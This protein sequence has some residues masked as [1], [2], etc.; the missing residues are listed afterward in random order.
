M[1][2]PSEEKGFVLITALLIMIILTLVGIGAILN[3]SV[4]INISRNERLHKEA[5]YSADAGGALVP[6]IIN[7]YMSTQP[8]IVG[9]PGNLPADIQSVMKNGNFLNNI[10]GAAQSNDVAANPDVQATSAG[11]QVNVVINQIARILPS[12]QDIVFQ[13]ESGVAAPVNIYY[14]ATCRGF[15][16]DN[17]SSDVEL[18]YK[19]IPTY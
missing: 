16:S 5:F 7:Y 15:S 10:N 1:I 14:G 3:S 6:R 18:Y 4:E 2:R 17:S 13:G 9:Y 12:G 11:R 19:Y 8:S